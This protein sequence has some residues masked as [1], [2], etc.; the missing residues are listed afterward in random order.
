PSGALVLDDLSGARAEV[1]RA[2]L[3]VRPAASASLLGMATA[4]AVAEVAQNALG[5]ACVVRWP[6]DVAL[7]AVLPHQRLCHISVEVDEAAD[8]AYISLRVA[9]G[10]LRAARH[11]TSVTDEQPASPLA[12]RADWRE[13]TLARTLHTLDVRLRAALN[14]GQEV[15]R[16]TLRQEWL[17]RLMVPRQARVFRLD[18]RRIAGTVTWAAH[19]DALRVR[20]ADGVEWRIPPEDVSA[21]CGA[22]WAQASAPSARSQ[23]H[24]V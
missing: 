11:A 13:V 2:V 20:R 6:W 1:T 8:V 19:D 10:R 12:G 17:R 9:F 24:R 3:I 16:E 22:G 5:Q 14:S 18:G 21:T 4:C 23:P 7:S 15:E